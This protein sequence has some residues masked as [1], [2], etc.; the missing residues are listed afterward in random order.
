MFPAG[1]PLLPFAG[2]AEA[3][4]LLWNGFH[5]CPAPLPLLLVLP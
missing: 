3:V 5:E 4:D 2:A 1:T